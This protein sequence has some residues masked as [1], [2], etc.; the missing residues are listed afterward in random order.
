MNSS[1]RTYTHIASG[2]L[3]FLLTVFPSF[4]AFADGHHGERKPAHQQGSQA[5]LPEELNPVDWLMNMV[6]RIIGLNQP[7]VPIPDQPLETPTET[8]VATPST[9]QSPDV[10]P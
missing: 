2:I 5:P 3:V 6:R 4:S 8:A 9:Q 7:T 10:Q 1:R